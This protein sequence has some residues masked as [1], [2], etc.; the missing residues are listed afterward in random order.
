M[1]HQSALLHWAN[2]RIKNL[3]PF[4]ANN[5]YCA[6]LLRQAGELMDEVTATILNRVPNQKYITYLVRTKHVP[7]ALEIH[8]ITCRGFVEQENILLNKVV[9]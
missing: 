7:L 5:R 1:R 9:Q 4:R 3:S 8:D 2:I 6:K